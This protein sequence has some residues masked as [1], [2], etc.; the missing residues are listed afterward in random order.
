MLG[1]MSLFGRERRRH[2][3]ARAGEGG[4]VL[5]FCS[6][7]AIR[8]LRARFPADFTEAISGLAGQVVER[9]DQANRRLVK[10]LAAERSEGLRRDLVV[11]DLRSP[12]GTVDSAVQA[13]LTRPD[14]YGK[15]G[16]K[17]RTA[18]VRVGKSLAFLRLLVDSILEVERARQSKTTLRDTS[19][20]EVLQAMAAPLL[21]V[22]A[23]E[24]WLSQGDEPVAQALQGTRLA[25]PPQEV[26]AQP[27]RADPLRLSQVL[28]NLI[29]NAVRYTEG[30]I[31]LSLQISGEQVALEL[32]DRGPGIP[33]DKRE[34]IFDAFKQ[35]EL[36]NS[37]LPVGKGFGLAGV[38]E[39]VVSMG[40]TITVH[41]R[42]DGAPGARFRLLLPAG[43]RP[44]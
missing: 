21:S 29:G 12:L 1:E 15:P 43:G 35:R 26:L 37:R 40:G 36:Q 25:L 10:V 41:D 3:E 28:L 22:V 44:V 34:S 38:R 42:L 39:M 30:P 14:V 18:L 17:Q 9:L 27:V 31:E 6:H 24:R 32:S 20:G 13:L 4:A 23:P 5:R 2:A 7:E 11:H 16:D 33:A 8:A 19:L